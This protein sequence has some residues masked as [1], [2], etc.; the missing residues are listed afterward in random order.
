MNIF[1]QILAS[2]YY[3][4]EEE[5]NPHIIKLFITL[6]K[7]IGFRFKRT[8]LVMNK[9]RDFMYF[10][11]QKYVLKEG[12]TVKDLTDFINFDYVTIFH[13]LKKSRDKYYSNPDSF[14]K[15]KRL[16][17]EGKGNNPGV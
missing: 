3:V 16:E 11:S 10:D 13:N 4:F 7:S 6:M 8:D 12:V 9:I 15:M 2:A 17:Y 5:L 14:K 1:D